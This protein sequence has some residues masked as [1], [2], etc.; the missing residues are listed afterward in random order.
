MFVLKKT[1]GIK[2]ETNGASVNGIIVLSSSTAG[3]S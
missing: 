1:Q 3:G 2:I